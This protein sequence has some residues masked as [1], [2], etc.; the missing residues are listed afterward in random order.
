MKII[1]E[2]VTAVAMTDRQIPQNF[3]FHGNYPNPLNSA[4]HFRFAPLK[5]GRVKLEI[6]NAIGQK[7]VT[8]LDEIRQSGIHEVEFNAGNLPSGLY[9]ARFQAGQLSDVR[10]F[11]LMK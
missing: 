4:T 11:L 7:V 2:D 9:L 5:Q 6:F 3:E 10:K 1:M 8:V